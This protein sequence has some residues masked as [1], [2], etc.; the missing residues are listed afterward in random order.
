MLDLWLPG[1]AGFAL[2][3]HVLV[4]QESSHRTMKGALTT[5]AC[6]Q[7]ETDMKRREDGRM[8]MHNM[9]SP[10]PAGHNQAPSGLR[11]PCPAM[12]QPG[13]PSPPPGGQ[14]PHGL[15]QREGVGRLMS[16]FARP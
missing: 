16:C 1:N 13:S 11:P 10:V 5:D 3:V 15:P 4:P 7:G 6:T 12:A 14:S 2:F 8:H 9:C